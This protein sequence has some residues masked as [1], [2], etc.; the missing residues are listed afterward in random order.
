MCIRDR[1][2]PVLVVEALADKYLEHQPIERQCRRWARA[3]VEVSPQTLGRSVAAAI[4][5]F[6]PVA[7]EIRKRTVASSLLAADSTGLPV[8]D[9]DVPTG[10]CV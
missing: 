4:D 10:R 3:G 5:L 1:L 9:Q 7:E 2:G 6:E 8:L